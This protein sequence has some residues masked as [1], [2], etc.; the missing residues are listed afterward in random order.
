MVGLSA[1]LGLSGVLRMLATNPRLLGLARSVLYVGSIQT[2][3]LENGSETRGYKLVKAVPIV[4]LLSRQEPTTR[5][6]LAQ[7]P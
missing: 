3:P 6:K 4:L 7:I 5:L 1:L 2:R